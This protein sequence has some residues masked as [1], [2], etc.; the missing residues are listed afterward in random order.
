[1]VSWKV[2]QILGVMIKLWDFNKNKQ[3]KKAQ[4]DFLSL[5]L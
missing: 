4:I 5:L 1:M 3:I 2:V